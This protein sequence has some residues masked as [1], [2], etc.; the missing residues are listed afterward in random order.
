MLSMEDRLSLGIMG[1]PTP[2]I[3]NISK[4][5]GGNIASGLPRNP[6][7]PGYNNPSLHPH[8]ILLPGLNVIIEN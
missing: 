6:G 4:N 2:D 3:V 5:M 8:P 1:L 7:P